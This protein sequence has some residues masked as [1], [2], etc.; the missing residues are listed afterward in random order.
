M[1]HKNRARP[2]A[3][4]KEAIFIIFLMDPKL[5]TKMKP[6]KKHKDLSSYQF[7]QVRA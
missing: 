2:W 7:L 5:R 6:N 4:W 3:E 1:C